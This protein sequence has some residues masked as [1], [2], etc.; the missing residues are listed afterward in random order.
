MSGYEFQVVPAPERVRKLTDLTKDQDKF[1][2]TVTDILTDMGLAGWE[3]VG[4]ETLP[5]HSR[6]MFIFSRTEQKTC[7]VFRREIE[8]AIKPKRVTLPSPESEILG[9]EP[10]R[11]ARPEVLAQFK[12]RR[13][14]EVASPVEDQRAIARIPTRRRRAPLRLDNPVEDGPVENGAVIPIKLNRSKEAKA[15]LSALERAVSYDPNAARNA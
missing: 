13:R 3:F 5:Y 10:V 9:P 2:A 14:I 6:R 7:L 11:Q 1:C 8:R 15:A 4:A 12:T